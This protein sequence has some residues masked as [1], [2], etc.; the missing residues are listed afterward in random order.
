MNI[1]LGSALAATL[2]PISLVFSRALAMVF[3]V[4]VVGF[5][6]RFLWAVQREVSRSHPACNRK[7]PLMKLSSWTAKSWRDLAVSRC[8]LHDVSHRKDSVD[9]AM[10]DD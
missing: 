1:L 7:R 6:L 8:S 3:V 9:V 10:T 5:Y 4:G 2:L